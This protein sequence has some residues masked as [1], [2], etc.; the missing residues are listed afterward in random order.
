MLFRSGRVTL[1]GWLGQ[2][3]AA[4]AASDQQFAYVNGRAV[5]DRLLA[6]AV[7]L[8]Y[9][10]VLYHGRQPAYLLY[11]DIDTEWVDVNAHPQKLEVRFR[12]S[13]QVH[14]LVFRSVH[15]ALGV[16]AG[17]AAPTPEGPMPW[18]L[19]IAASLDGLTIAWVDSRPG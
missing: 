7:R 15:D 2:P 8:G 6:A 13:R 3:Q 19:L 18:W 9:R 11:L 4:R 12:D 14:D 10:D 5:R 1:S 17:I 16:G